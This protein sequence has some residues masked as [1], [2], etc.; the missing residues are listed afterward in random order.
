MS[1]KIQ[2]VERRLAWNYERNRQIYDQVLAEVIDAPKIAQLLRE[3]E[4]NA[5]RRE[6]FTRQLEIEIEKSKQNW[7][8]RLFG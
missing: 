8:D 1:K 2:E 4:T 6:H 7:W 5:L 3:L